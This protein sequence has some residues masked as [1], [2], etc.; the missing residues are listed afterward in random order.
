[1]DSV[2]K[3]KQDQ[4]LQKGKQITDMAWGKTHGAQNKG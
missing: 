3:E 4:Q 1:M 2:E